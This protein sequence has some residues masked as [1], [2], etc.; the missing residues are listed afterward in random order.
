MLLKIFKTVNIRTRNSIVSIMRSSKTFSVLAFIII[1][2][3][4]AIIWDGSSFENEI[5]Q[6]AQRQPYF[7]E[8]MARNGQNYPV[9]SRISALELELASDEINQASEE[10]KYKSLLLDGGLNCGNVRVGLGLFGKRYPAQTQL[11]PII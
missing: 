7:D 1:C 2:V 11:V 9:C 4:L 10:K 5:V 6:A 3:G 8:V